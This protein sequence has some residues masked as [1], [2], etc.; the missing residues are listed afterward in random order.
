MKVLVVG[1]GAR[2]HAIAWKIGQSDLLSELHVTPG[3]LGMAA[4]ATCHDAPL[5][6]IDAIARLSEELAVD[7]VVV[8]AEAPLVAGLSNRL[9]KL[10]IPCFGPSAAGARLEG[11]KVSAK[12]LMDRAQ[13]PT[14]RWEAFSDV[15]AALAAINRWRGPVVIKADGLAAGTGVFVCMTKVQAERALNML[16]VDSAFGVAGRRVVVEEFLQG[17]EASVSVITDGETVLPLPVVRSEKRRDDNNHGP[18]TDGMGAWAPVEE[19]YDQQIEEAI[20][21]GIKPAL[22][23]LAGRGM[24]YVGVL[25]ADVMFTKTGPKVLEYNCRFGDLEVQALVR[26]LDVDLLEVLHRAATGALDGVE[27]PELSEAVV[28]MQLVSASYPQS[29]HDDTHVAIGGL[30]DASEVD[31]VELFVGNAVATGKG[32]KA[33]IASAGGR[34]LTVTATAGTVEEAAARARSASDLIVFEGKHV[35]SDIAAEAGVYA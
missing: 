33:G 24:P 11:S 4:F 13:V 1:S 12:E 22:A 3:N 9:K 10:G 7:L 8:G 14:A 20:E 32:A 16:L 31:G 18:N 2:E 30:A 35:R 29:D 19:L 28:A 5:H 26:S 25:Y 27:L 21:A 34:V 17:I 15:Q 23:D 6:D